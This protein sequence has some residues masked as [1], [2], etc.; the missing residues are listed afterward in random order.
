MAASQGKNRQKSA[1]P[2]RKS[3]TISHLPPRLIIGISGASGVAYGV[4]LLR[5]LQDSM[6]ETHLVISRAAQVTLAHETDH[7][8]QEIRDLADVYYDIDDMAAAISSGSFLT[9]GMIVAPCSVKTLA[10]IATGVTTTLISRAADVVLKERR[11][12]VLMVRET[13][14]HA[15]HLKNMLAVTEMGGI[16]APPVPALYAKPQTL[17]DMIDHNLGRALDL[18][19]IASDRVHRWGQEKVDRRKDR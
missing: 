9:L 19:G 12:L 4:R 2:T 1:T 11:R 5:M 13:P 3:E 7:K 17:E 8:I 18:F 14:L 6:I 15:G 16:I 10:E